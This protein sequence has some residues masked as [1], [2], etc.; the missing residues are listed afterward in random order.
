MSEPLTTDII[1]PTSL[2]DRIAGLMVLL[3]KANP[4]DILYDFKNLRTLAGCIQT[5]IQ[6]V[7][8]PWVICHLCKPPLRLEME[9]V[10]EHDTTIHN[11]YKSR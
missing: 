7:R 6:K 1:L 10:Y 3:Q 4:A 5:E 11:A 9:K 2:V 8:G